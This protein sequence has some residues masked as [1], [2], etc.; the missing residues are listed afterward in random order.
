MPIQ[1]QRFKFA[2][3]ETNVAV[4]DFI[5]SKT[6]DL[7]NSPNNVLKDIDKDM[8][9]FLDQAKSAVK[10]DL[11]MPDSL[12]DLARKSKDAWT[13]VKDLSKLG[14]NDLNKYVDGLFPNNPLAVASF[15]KLSQSC[16]T[17]SSGHYNSGKPFDKSVNCNGKNRASPGGCG[18]G[19][20]DILNKLSGGDYNAAHRDLN[21]ALSNLVSLATMGYKANLCGVFNALTGGLDSNLLKSRGASMLLG[22]LG[23][24]GNI[25]GVFDLAAST[26]GSAFSVI[27]DIPNGVS[28][29][30][31]NFKIPFDAK[32]TELSSIAD[33]TNLSMDSFYS[34]WKNSEYDNIPSVTALTNVTDDFKDVLKAKSMDVSINEDDL[35]HI[36]SS[37][38]ISTRAACASMGLT[39][40]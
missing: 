19:I 4:S 8:S 33:S 16:K 15:K 11:K 12:G 10:I 32:Q 22:S 13:S 23:S 20:G 27:K 35:D 25:R 34:K 28:N 39:L 38:T 26:G 21:S 30:F 7:F 36:P 5:D 6:S 24:A 18:S 14:Q 1:A 37:D 3:A 40:I 2:D 9:S 17:S 29:V 31:S